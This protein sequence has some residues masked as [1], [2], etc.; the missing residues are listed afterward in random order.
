MVELDSQARLNTQNAGKA[1]DISAGALVSAKQ[2]NDHMGNMLIAM[3]DIT[4]K[5]RQVQGIIKI[6]DEIAFQ[7]NLLALNAAVE[8]ARAGIHGRGFAVVAEEVR[9]LA[10]R[11]AKA[12]GETNTIIEA[13]LSS[14]TSGSS[15]AEDTASSLTEIIN[16]ITQV[17]ELVDT[18][19]HSGEEQT[20]VTHEIT[21]ALS[22]I[23]GVT[24]SNAALAEETAAAAEELHS[25][26]TQLDH[27]LSNFKVR[28]EDQPNER[29]TD[30]TNQ[31][32]NKSSF[33]SAFDTIKLDDVVA[34]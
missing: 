21:R 18:I 8:A 16:S 19:A 2:G 7:T 27:M 32:A 12:A 4:V 3:E 9:S 29:P 25:Q 5:S 24:Q 23:D 6:I 13:N 30:R 14:V 17:T 33:D 20:S 34:D 15:I 1:R 31:T 28:S 11:S 26:V 10:Q 22:E